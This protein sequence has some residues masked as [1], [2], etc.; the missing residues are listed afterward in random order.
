MALNDAIKK[1]CELRLRPLLLTTLTTMFG[2]IPLLWAT[3]SGAEIQKPLAIVVLG[4]L[5]SSWVLTLVVL[6]A[7]YGWFEKEEIEF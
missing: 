7:L 4:G 5:I 1:G 3:G 6:P 2:L